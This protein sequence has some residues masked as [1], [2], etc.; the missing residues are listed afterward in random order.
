MCSYGTEKNGGTVKHNLYVSSNGLRDSLLNF[1][2][3]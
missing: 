2:G 1:G 3:V